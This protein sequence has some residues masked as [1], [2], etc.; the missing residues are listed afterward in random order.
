M[1]IFIVHH[2]ADFDGFFS[3]LITAM[4]VIKNLKV[5]IDD[6]I[7]VP[8]N[9]GDKLYINKKED[10]ELID[11]VEYN[12]Y[13]FFVDCSWTKNR[14]LYDELIKKIGDPAQIEMI[15]HHDSAIDWVSK[16][17]HD[18]S[19]SASEN[20]SNPNLE[21]PRSAAALCWDYFFTNIQIPKIVELVSE[22]DIWYKK[23]PTKWDEE[24]LPFQ[25][26]LRNKGIDMWKIKDYFEEWSKILEPC[27]NS[28]TIKLVEDTI[29]DGKAIIEYQKSRSKTVVRTTGFEAFLD[30]NDESYFAYFAADYCANSTL[31]EWGLPEEDQKKYDIFVLCRPV[32]GETRSYTTII[33]NKEGIS[34]AEICAKFGGGGH[35]KVAGCRVN[36]EKHYIR[37]DDEYRVTLKEYEEPSND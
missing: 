13:V 18:I 33:S 4:G 19:Y 5:S 36:I 27:N 9:Y 22:Y 17:A 31:F 28:Y 37:E 2:S 20:S 8:Y 15:D 24:I 11:K 29:N 21:Y 12:D 30:V 7:F 6:I 1:K 23:D 16:N 35:V 10:I 26:G 14:E 3:G 34:A 32:I 25:Y